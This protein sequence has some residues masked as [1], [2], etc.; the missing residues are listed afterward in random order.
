MSGLF[1]VVPWSMMSW[2]RSSPSALPLIWTM[3]A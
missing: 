3:A 1:T 2:T